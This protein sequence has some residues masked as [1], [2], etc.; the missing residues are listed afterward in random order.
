ML[1]D[2]LRAMG[3]AVPPGGAVTLPRDW[4]MAELDGAG[5]PSDP[6]LTVDLTVPDLAALLGKRDPTEVLPLAQEVWGPTEDV[7]KQRGEILWTIDLLQ[8][9]ENSIVTR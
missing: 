2:R 7:R 6:A 1:L 4:I 5:T 9:S 3:E 8:S